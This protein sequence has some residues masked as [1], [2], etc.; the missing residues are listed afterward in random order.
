M[1]LLLG[2]D[3]IGVTPS[4]DLEM[5]TLPL[6]SLLTWLPAADGEPLDHPGLPFARLIDSFVDMPKARPGTVV[7][8]PESVESDT[9]TYSWVTCTRKDID[10]WSHDDR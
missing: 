4:S 2:P 9:S 8:G 1:Q 7:A 3:H 5:S 6:G 10:D